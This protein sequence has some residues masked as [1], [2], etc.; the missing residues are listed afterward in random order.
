MILALPHDH[1][2]HQRFR[3]VVGA[4]MGRDHAFILRAALCVGF[5]RKDNTAAAA[6]RRLGKFSSNNLSANGISCL[7]LLRSP[8]GG[9]AKRR[10][11]CD[12]MCARLPSFDNGTTAMLRC[13]DGVSRLRLIC[14]TPTRRI[15]VQRTQSRCKKF[16]SVKACVPTAKLSHRAND[17][18][19]TKVRREMRLWLD[20]IPAIYRAET[21]CSMWQADPATRLG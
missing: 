9:A 2:M 14:V 17:K 4:G 5:G 13:V 18:I 10:Q 1:A 19:R 6:S 8:G 3:H 15:V 11:H 7:S 21:L 16:P 12:Q 20:S